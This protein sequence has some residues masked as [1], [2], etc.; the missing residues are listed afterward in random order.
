MVLEVKN[1]N[2]KESTFRVTAKSGKITKTVTVKIE[3]KETTETRY[4]QE[5]VKQIETLINEVKNIDDKNV[6]SIEKAVNKIDVM[7]KMKK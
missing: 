7:L 4:K 3:N 6:E 2:E 5:V 1:S